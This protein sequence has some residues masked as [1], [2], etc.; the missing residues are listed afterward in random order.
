MIYD[1]DDEE[2]AF[3]QV[4]NIAAYHQNLETYVT[5]KLG[6]NRILK[7]EAVINKITDWLRL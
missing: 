6:H 5:E 7:D 4:E 3:E 2:I 1:R